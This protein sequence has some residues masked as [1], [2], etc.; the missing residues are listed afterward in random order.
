LIDHGQVDR[1][2][3]E[4][5]QVVTPAEL[6]MWLDNL[7]QH[8]GVDQVTVIFDACFSGSF[9]DLYEVTEQ[10]VTYGA[11]TLSRDDRQ[12]VIVSS[13]SSDWWAYGPP[14]DGSWEPYLFFSNGFLHALGP[15]GGFQNVWNAYQAGVQYVEAMGQEPGWGHSVGLQAPWLDDNGDQRMDN[16]DGTQAQQRGLGHAVALGGTAPYIESLTVT[17]VNEA[18]EATI[19]AEV[20]DDGAVE[21]VWARIFAPSFESP[22]GEDG[23]IPVIEVPEVELEK[24]S[25][26]AFRG[27]HSEFTEK[28]AYQIGVYARDEDGNYA[29]PRWVLVGEKKVYLPLVIRGGS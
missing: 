14:T 4:I 25:S 19:I 26:G 6:D 18:A 2:H 29:R 17:E 15:E 13:T 22:Q 12:R 16:S 20:V 5:E 24:K 10:G 21:A 7:E 9:I 1:F 3:N 8:R 23:S 11:E 27:K 28:G